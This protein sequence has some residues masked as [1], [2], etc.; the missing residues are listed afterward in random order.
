MKHV[1][2]LLTTLAT[3]VVF[4]TLI[5]IVLTLMVIKEGRFLTVFV[6]SQLTGLSICLFVRAG[7][8]ISEKKLNALPSKKRPP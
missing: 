3:T 8:F 2:H 7:I 5:A 6:I 4:N 1:K